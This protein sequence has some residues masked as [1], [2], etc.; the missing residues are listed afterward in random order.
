MYYVGCD[1]HKK[2][3][4]VVCKDQNGNHIDQIKLYHNEKDKMKEYFR[5]LPEDSII[6]L[7]ACGFD[8]WIGKQ[9]YQ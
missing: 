6:G 5:R 1:Q 4:Y 7:E 2:Y 3:S 9:I 8:H